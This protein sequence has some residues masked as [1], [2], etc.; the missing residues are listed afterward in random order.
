MSV[1]LCG[2]VLQAAE[3]TRQVS[4]EELLGVLPPSRSMPEFTSKDRTNGFAIWMGDY[5]T[6]FFE[7]EPP[8]ASDLSRG[9]V[10]ETLAGADEP[11]VVGV[12]GLRDLG[13]VGLW[14]KES[15]FPL[16][17]MTADFQDRSVPPPPVNGR[18][19]LGIPQWLP[20]QATARIEQRRNTVFWINVRVPKDTEPGTYNGLLWLVVHEREIVDKDTGGR[21]F[22]IPFTVKVLP[23]E[24]DRTDIAYGMYFRGSASGKYL[25]VPYNSREM[26]TKYY[27]DMVRHGMTSVTLYVYEKL[28]DK[29]GNLKLDN[30]KLTKEID[31]LLGLGLLHRDIP[32]IMLSGAI[33][34]KKA[35]EQ[36][37]QERQSRGWPELLIYAPDGP[38]QR[39][40]KRR[41]QAAK[42][43]RNLQ[44]LRP[45]LRLV[46]SI[47]KDSG[48]F[49]AKDLD[50][51]IVNS[52]VS[53]SENSELQSQ[54]RQ[55]GAE[56]WT[57]DCRQGTNPV[58][59]RFFAGL[60]TWALGMK[61]NFLWGYTGGYQWEYD[62]F[63]SVCYVLP[64]LAGPVTSVG[65]EMRRE[66][67]EDYRYLITLERLSKNSGNKKV[68]EEAG[69]WLGELR[70]EV[71]ANIRE[72]MPAV[73]H[74]WDAADLY[75]GCPEFN[76]AEFDAIR[77]KAGEYIMKLQ[78]KEIF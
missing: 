5:T 6:P 32:V 50:V 65:W 4:D 69:R 57:R 66:G 11:L 44:P 26:M 73:R 31:A 51:W 33:K 42:G 18:R 16:T 40:G 20:V 59:N 37:K 62:R 64:S 54:A 22:K 34:D 23:I 28:F 21:I 27:E 49:A 58:F 12:W 72:R 56:V 39:E 61:G 7:K 46:T 10:C 19:R 30:K 17:V 67:V 36:L 13:T 45:E 53:E 41:E 14:V 8:F 70:K 52:L 35:A 76:P 2:S 15:P 3:G 63:A 55:V 75:S 1:I 9:A 47:S 38:Y 29:S 77:Q 24:L 60:Y 74:G 43:L 68:A 25:P 48:R 78:K 71:H